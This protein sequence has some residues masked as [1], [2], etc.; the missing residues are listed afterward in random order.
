MRASETR[1]S[2]AVPS[3][4]SRALER[5]AEEPCV[6]RRRSSSPGFRQGTEKVEGHGAG[7]GEWVFSSPLTD[8]LTT[9]QICSYGQR[10]SGLATSAGLASETPF[11]Q[12]RESPAVQKGAAKSMRHEASMT[13]HYGNN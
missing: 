6:N 5:E 4:L 10:E 9:N 3:Q 2:I 13:R 1:S 11:R 8:G 7:V 12:I